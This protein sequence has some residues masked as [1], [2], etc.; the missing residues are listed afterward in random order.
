M[1]EQLLPLMYRTMQRIRRFEE[2]T[3]DLIEAGEIKTP[4][5]LYIGKAT[6]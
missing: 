3:A 1:S 2:R 5:H 6:G 4:C